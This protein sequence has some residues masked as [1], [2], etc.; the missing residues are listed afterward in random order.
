MPES[1]ITIK[2][3]NKKEKIK[4]VLLNTHTLNTF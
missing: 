2:K 1:K 4:A 3:E